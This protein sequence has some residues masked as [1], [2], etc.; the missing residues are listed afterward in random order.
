MNEVVSIFRTR[1]SPE[2]TTPLTPNA[3]ILNLV[4]DELEN[5]IDY[6]A[7]LLHTAATQ[8]ERRAAWG[9]LT[10]LHAMRSPARIEQMESE[11]GLR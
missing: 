8:D 11:A 5:R 9:E 4:P 10:R 6:Q 2:A 1:V 7:M 3:P